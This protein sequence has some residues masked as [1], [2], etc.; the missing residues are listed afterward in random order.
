M[1]SEEKQPLCL[2][3]HPPHLTPHDL[4]SLLSPVLQQLDNWTR[5]PVFLMGP[6]AAVGRKILAQVNCTFNIRPVFPNLTD[7]TSWTVPIYNL[8]AGE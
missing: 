4:N 5:P 8:P 3:V 6:V 2:L 7:S 1:S